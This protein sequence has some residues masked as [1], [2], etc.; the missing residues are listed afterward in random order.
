MQ[1]PRPTSEEL[2]VEVNELRSTASRLIEQASR[3][4]ER[5]GELETHISLN[6]KATKVLTMRIACRLELQKMRMER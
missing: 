4:V 3:L 6:F 2:R 5:C 1:W